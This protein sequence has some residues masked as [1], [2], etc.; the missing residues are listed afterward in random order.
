MQN[1]CGR[2]KSLVVPGNFP[3]FER[4]EEGGGYVILW[5]T[6]KAVSSALSHRCVPLKPLRSACT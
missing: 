6:A 1:Y 5:A 3:S 4:S 2:Q